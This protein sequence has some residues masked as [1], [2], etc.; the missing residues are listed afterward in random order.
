M[1]GTWDSI[2][3]V[4]VKDSKKNANYKL[5]STVMLGIETETEATGSVNLSGSLTRQV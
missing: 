3:V 2:H 1:K 5:T 4:E